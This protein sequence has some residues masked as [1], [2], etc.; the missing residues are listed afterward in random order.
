MIAIMAGNS[1]KPPPTVIAMPM[2]NKV[3]HGFRPVV[4]LRV[5]SRCER[6]DRGTS[7]TSLGTGAGA[8]VAVTASEAAGDGPCGGGFAA[9]AM[10]I[11]SQF[12]HCTIFPISSGDNCSR[13]RQFG[14][15]TVSFMTSLAKDRVIASWLDEILCLVGAIARILPP[16]PSIA[17]KN[18]WTCCTIGDTI[19]SLIHL[20]TRNQP[21]GNVF[22]P[23]LGRPP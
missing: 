12:G 20:F 14:H 22:E 16:M 23:W 4:G 3:C 11:V 15:T 7:S 6:R 13:R 18:L 1:T 10:N 21:C 2:I 19:R 8:R 5:S 9:P 17:S